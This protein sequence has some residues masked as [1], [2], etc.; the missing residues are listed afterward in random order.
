[1]PW[2]LFEIRGANVPTFD[3]ILKCRRHHEGDVPWIAGSN[4]CQQF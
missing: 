4:F 3:V 1:M 2:D